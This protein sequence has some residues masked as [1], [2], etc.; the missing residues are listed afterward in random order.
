ML[1]ITRWLLPVFL[2]AMAGCGKKEENEAEPIVPVQ[3]TAV[4]HDSIR[5]ILTA[6]AVL[7][8]Q[9]QASVTPKISAPVKKFYV[10][11]GDHV[12]EGQLLALLEN[13]DLSAAALE[14]KGLY[15]QAAANYRATSAASLPEQVTTAQSNVEAAKEALDAAIFISFPVS[16]IGFCHSTGRK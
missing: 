2:V 15:E 11:R 13:R 9:N 16:S 4:R 7:Y 8:P 14:S 5:R 3:V 6:D 10:N 1:K 12:K